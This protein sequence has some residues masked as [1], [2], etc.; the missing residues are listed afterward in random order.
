MNYM[1]AREGVCLKH[2]N[3]KYFSEVYKRVQTHAREKYNKITIR[4]EQLKNLIIVSKMRA[5]KGYPTYDFEN[6][7][8]KDLERTEEHLKRFVAANADYLI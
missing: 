3:P 8:L 2:I 1:D 5:A 6:I 7:H 4:V